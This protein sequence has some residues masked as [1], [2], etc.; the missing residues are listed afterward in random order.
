MTIAE[1]FLLIARALK[2]NRIPYAMAGG[3]ATNLWVSD[4]DSRETH[5]VDFA[6]A[7]SFPDPASDVLVYLARHG[8]Y[9]IE[10]LVDSKLPKANILKFVVGGIN[11][12]FVVVHD[13]EYA[14]TAIRRAARSRFMGRSKIRILTPEDIFLYKAMANRHKDIS[15]MAALSKDKDFDWEYVERWA[16]RLGAWSVA[17]KFVL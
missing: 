17:K 1:T 16:R 4:E 3:M 2:A 15:P 13:E 10:R 11:V 6:L 14:K 7:V 12:D 5:D 9:C 8:K